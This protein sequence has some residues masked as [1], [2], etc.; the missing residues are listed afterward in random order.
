V[1]GFGSYHDDEIGVAGQAGGGGMH[2]EGESEDCGWLRLE[3]LA[4]VSV[5]C[6]VVNGRYWYSACI[7]LGS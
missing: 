3:M 2:G 1:F 7:A 6:V 5:L 4:A